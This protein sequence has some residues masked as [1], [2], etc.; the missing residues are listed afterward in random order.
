MATGNRITDNETGIVLDDADAA[1]AADDNWWGCN[2]G[3][4]SPDCDSI[5]GAN[6]GAIDASRVL[7]LAIDAPSRIRPRRKRT[8]TASLEGGSVCLFPGGTQIRFATNKGRVRPATAETE[9]CAASVTLKARRRTRGNI[10]VSALLDNQGV[11]ATVRV[12]RN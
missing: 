6:V 9:A 7:A 2:E 5:G 1:V 12:V 10:T 3:L 4:P 8:V 11:E